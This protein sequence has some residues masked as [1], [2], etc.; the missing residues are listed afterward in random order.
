MADDYYSSS[1]GDEA[2]AG[3]G[4]DEG[5]EGGER[6]ER[7]DTGMGE[8]TL[9]PKSM[10]EGKEL[11][12]GDEF[13]FTVVRVLENEVEVSY[14]HDESKEKEGEGDEGAETPEGAFD[15]K[16]SMMGGGGG[17]GGGY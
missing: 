16:F 11:K 2:E 12:P 14:K 7:S 4:A 6:S 1:G 3:A 9:V 17:G 8:T 10:F 5:M 13:Y 15:A